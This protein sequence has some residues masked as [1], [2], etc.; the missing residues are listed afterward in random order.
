MGTELWQKS[1]QSSSGHTRPGQQSSPK[2]L[3]GWSRALG[4]ALGT[5]QERGLAEDAHGAAASRAGRRVLHSIRAADGV[6][7]ILRALT[8]RVTLQAVVSRAR[9]GHGQRVHAMGIIIIIIINVHFT[10]K[11]NCACAGSTENPREFHPHSALPGQSIPTTNS[12]TRHPLAPKR[13]LGVLATPP[14]GR[15]IPLGATGQGM[16]RELTQTCIEPSGHTTRSC[17]RPAATACKV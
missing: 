10:E 6:K 12:P 3:P 5:H 17:P 16:S 11:I 9:A 13:A 4:R 2:Q 8:G 1:R 15:D 14:C 7:S